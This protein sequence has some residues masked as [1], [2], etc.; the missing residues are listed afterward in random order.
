MGKTGM[1]SS[2]KRPHVWILVEGWV[3]KAEVGSVL[4]SAIVQ[5]APLSE[6]ASF[7][8]GIRDGKLFAVDQFTLDQWQTSEKAFLSWSPPLR[9]VQVLYGTTPKSSA[10]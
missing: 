3:K 6:I 5:W 8:Q 1:L 7:S 9:W 2:D 4:R 10:K